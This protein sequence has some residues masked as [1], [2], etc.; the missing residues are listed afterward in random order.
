MTKDLR[1]IVKAGCRTFSAGIFISFTLLFYI[2]FT[3]FVCYTAYGGIWEMKYRHVIL[4]GIDAAVR[5]IDLPAI[6]AHALG[7][8][9]DPLWES[10]VPEGLFDQ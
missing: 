3:F 1:S 5:T 2:D 4:I 10:R 8:P 7:V 9:A 6:V